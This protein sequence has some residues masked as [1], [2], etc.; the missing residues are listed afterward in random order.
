[1]NGILGQ[2]NTK[3]QCSL[4]T[5]CRLA[6]GYPDSQEDLM[7]VLNCS[8]QESQYLIQQQKKSN[9]NPE[10]A[11]KNKINVYLEVKQELKRIPVSLF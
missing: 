5:F 8:K 3:L 4:S 1:M 11:D 9:V 6:P 10:Y 7:F 2:H